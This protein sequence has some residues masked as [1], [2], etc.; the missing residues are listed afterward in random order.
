MKFFRRNALRGDQSSQGQT[1]DGE[2]HRRAEMGEQGNPQTRHFLISRPPLP[3]LALFTGRSRTGVRS[4][5]IDVNPREDDSPKTPRFNLGLPNMPS[6]R[7]RLPNL[8]RPGTQGSSGPTSPTRT[9]GLSVPDPRPSPPLIQVQQTP[10][11]FEPAPS[12]GSL[13]F[14]G[15]DAG[16]PQFRGADF[17]ETSLAA[18]IDRRRRRRHRN[19]RHTHDDRHDERPRKFLFCFPWVKSRRIRSLILRCFVSGIFLMLMLAVYLALSI[20]KNINS[21]E[22]TV[23][24]ILVILFATIFFCHGLIR[25]CMF[26]VKPP[27]EDVEE[28]RLPQLMEPGGY[29]VPRRPIHVVLARD[30]EV[31][32]NAGT[33]NKLQ[34]PAYGLWRESVRVDPNRLYWQRNEQPPTDE[35][36]EERHRPETVHTRPPSY[37]SED[38]VSYVVEARPR[39]IVPPIDVTLPPHSSEVGRLHVM[40]RT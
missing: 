22:F 26:I 38:G 16:L 30:E 29:A 28:G 4:E 8:T 10:V 1:Q 23:L 12:H 13:S 31:T 37:A 25:I 19:R 33:A 40:E 9:Y 21:N 11:V 5:A 14:A 7:L 3:T 18:S 34:P 15:D 24:L 27:N 20:T 6:T 35:S 32:E 36:E 2:H 17:A 39:S